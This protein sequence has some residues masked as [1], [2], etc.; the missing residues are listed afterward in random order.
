MS[1]ITNET[2]LTYLYERSEIGFY[3]AEGV[4]YDPEY[5]SYHYK[6]GEQFDPRRFY[7]DVWFRRAEFKYNNGDECP[8]SNQLPAGCN[9]FSQS[10]DIINFLEIGPMS[11]CSKT[12]NQD[13][14]SVSAAWEDQIPCTFAIKSIENPRCMFWSSHVDGHCSCVEAYDHATGRGAYLDRIKNI[15]VSDEKREQK[16]HPIDLK[17]HFEDAENVSIH[18]LQDWNDDG[19][20]TKVHSN[21]YYYAKWDVYFN[22]NGAFLERLTTQRRKYD[23]DPADLERLGV[24][25]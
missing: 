5:N 4:F 13:R 17:K 23:S 2:D 18:L 20:L 10:G 9:P 11:M 12:K 16:K 3:G 1:R 19:T 6:N 14:N 25:R 21:V 7:N 15:K 8:L 24:S 22:S